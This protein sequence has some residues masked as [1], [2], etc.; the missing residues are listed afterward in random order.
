METQEIAPNPV[1]YEYT[2]N[3][4]EL[5]VLCTS[6]AD[7]VKDLNEKLAVE[8]VKNPFEI[9]F[10]GCAYILAVNSFTRLPSFEF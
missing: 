9:L 10:L 5:D 8:K 1:F 2:D 3:E 6:V 7:A 4:D